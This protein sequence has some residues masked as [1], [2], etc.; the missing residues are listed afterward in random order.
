MSST[1][2][3]KT[4]QKKTQQKKKL[5]RQKAETA[6]TQTQRRNRILRDLITPKYYAHIL[7]FLQKMDT[8][9]LTYYLINNMKD[10]KKNITNINNIKNIMNYKPMSA[11][12]IYEIKNYEINDGVILLT[13]AKLSID[14]LTYIILSTYDIEKSKAEWA[15]LTKNIEIPNDILNDIENALT[16]SVTSTGTKPTGTKPAGAQS[17]YHQY[18]YKS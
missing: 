3:K 5:T 11:D 8:N 18:C 1:Q 2:Q 13:F 17:K 9:L 6:E 7:P 14:E 12:K 10:G 16:I 15:S 4:Q